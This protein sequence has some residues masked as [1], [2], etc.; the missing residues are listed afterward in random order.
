MLEPC[1]T[2]I[3]SFLQAQAP[4]VELQRVVLRPELERRQVPS[5]EGPKQPGFEAVSS[6]Q[7]AKAGYPRA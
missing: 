7:E 3:V 2:T 4:P 1:M 5:H 6:E